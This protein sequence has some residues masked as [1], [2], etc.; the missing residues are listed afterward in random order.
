MACADGRRESAKT[1]MTLEVDEERNSNDDKSR[2][3]RRKGKESGKGRLGGRAVQRT[4]VHKREG[5]AR[6]VS[7]WVGGWRDFGSLR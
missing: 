5:R 1:K 7:E 3:R 4:G 6:E 2:T